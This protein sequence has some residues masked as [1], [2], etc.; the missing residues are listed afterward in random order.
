MNKR[1]FLKTGLVLGAVTVLQPNELSAFGQ[2]AN[3]F[4]L[5]D[6]PYPVDA[7]EPHIDKMTMEFHHGKHHAAYIKNLNEGIQGTAFEKLTLAEILAKVSDKE[8]K[9]RNNGGGH[10]NHS[11]FWTLMSPKGGGNPAGKLGVAIKSKFGSFDK[12]KE[13]FSN[14]GKGLFGSG[15]VWLAFDPK[16]GL[17]V[18][19]TPNQ[20]NPLMSKIVKETGTPLLGLDVWEHAYYLK[21]QNRRAD[22]ITAFWN[23]INWEEANTRYAELLGKK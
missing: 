10:Y 7:L 8:A 23:V 14:A 19:T 13:L 12:F 1:N 11:F 4:K 3:E 17:F 6:L 18:S 5:P 2:Q 21:Y 22:Y 16:K 15:W 20:D 9:I